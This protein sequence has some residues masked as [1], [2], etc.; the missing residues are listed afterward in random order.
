MMPSDAVNCLRYFLMP[1]FSMFCHH[2]L[3][4][5]I[6]FSLI[7]FGY[8]RESVN[9]V[10]NDLFVQLV[11]IWRLPFG[12]PAFHF[13]AIRLGPLMVPVGIG[14]DALFRDTTSA[15]TFL[16]TPCLEPKGLDPLG[17]LT[18]GLDCSFAYLDKYKSVKIIPNSTY[19]R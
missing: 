19:V 3:F 15:W 16:S 8:L 11:A 1:S 12:T 14:W 17:G 2:L 6:R 4:A 5:A 13:S 7:L 10:I 9:K 18:E